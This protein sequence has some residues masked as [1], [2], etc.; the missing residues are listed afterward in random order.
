MGVTRKKREE[1]VVKTLVYANVRHR[2]LTLVNVR[3][4]D[5]S[6]NI[7]ALSFSASVFVVMEERSFS[8]SII[9]SLIIIK[10]IMILLFFY[11][12]LGV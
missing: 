4:S 10:L 12:S 8:F 11:F 5:H 3:Y 7:R 9:K 1:E 6:F 2:E